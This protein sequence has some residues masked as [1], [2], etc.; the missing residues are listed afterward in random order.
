MDVHKEVILV[1]KLFLAAALGGIVGLE[2]ELRRKPAGLRTNM[3]ISIGSA[4]F[5]ILSIELA[6]LSQISD[7]TRIAA[8]IIT[9][10]GFLGAG[11]ILH[12]QMTVTGLT[13]AATI[14][15]VAGIG[16]AVGAGFY[17]AASIS[18]GIILSTLYL[19]GLMETRILNKCEMFHY[20]VAGEDTGETM[21]AIEQILKQRGLLIEGISFKKE[22]HHFK[23]SFGVCTTKEENDELIKRF[24]EIK[25]LTAVNRE[26]Q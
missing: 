8:Q 3:L 22:N 4:L 11:A 13:T 23:L 20:S 14:Y 26:E 16:M 6:H 5:T 19:M 21:I 7:V 1:L 24:L 12:S 10:I 17:T 9:G 18:T 25:A 2:R 15:V